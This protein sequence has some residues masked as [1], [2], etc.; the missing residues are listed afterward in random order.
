[1][2]PTLIDGPVLFYREEVMFGKKCPSCGAKNSKERMTCIQCSA[3]FR[4]FW[5]N[6]YH[7]FLKIV[8]DC[9]HDELN[10]KIKKR[11]AQ[12]NKYPFL[13]FSPPEPARPVNT[14]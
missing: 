12:D 8:D 6:P 9:L 4:I 13:H 14:E 5:A 3:P 2:K 1:M 11:Q 7:R 10:T